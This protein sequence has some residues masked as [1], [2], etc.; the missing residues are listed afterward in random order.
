MNDAEVGIGERS[1]GRRHDAAAAASCSS[2]SAAF[3]DTM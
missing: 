2:T 1:S 3:S